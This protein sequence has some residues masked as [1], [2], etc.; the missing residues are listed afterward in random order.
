MADT[1][2]AA[3]MLTEQ[4]VDVP[5][6]APDQPPNVLPE[7]GAAVRVTLW[8]AVKE[9]EQV[10]PQLM[11]DGLLVTVPL[12]VLVT[13]STYVGCDDKPNV[14]VTLLAASIVT[15]QVP[16]PLQPPPLQPVNVLPEPGLA[17][18]VTPAPAVKD[19]EQSVGQLMP[20]PVTVPLPSPAVPTES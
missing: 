12:P 1:A 17:V 19:S 3:V 16:V 2:F 18:K 9:A 7:V 8:P 11:P 5:E 4:V 14:A 15:L 13:V 6:H 20:V 10:A